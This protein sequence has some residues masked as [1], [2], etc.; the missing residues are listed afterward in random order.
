MNYDKRPPTWCFCELCIVYVV[1]L[2]AVYFYS[3]QMSDFCRKINIIFKFLIFHLPPK[4]LLW[5]LF[6]GSLIIIYISILLQICASMNNE[7][8]LTHI[9]FCC[10]VELIKLNGMFWNFGKHFSPFNLWNIFFCCCLDLSQVP[11]IKSIIYDSSFSF[12]CFYFFY[13]RI[14]CEFFYCYEKFGI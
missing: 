11:Q 13:S 4:L 6:N 3:V 10:L 7:C 2:F 9:F 5:E 14:Y 1:C 12:C 8:F